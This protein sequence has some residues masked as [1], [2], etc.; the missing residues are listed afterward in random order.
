MGI[1]VVVP[2]RSTYE[3]GCNSISRHYN[4]SVSSAVGEHAF[5]GLKMV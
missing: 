3:P 1:E 5:L 2:D 4:F